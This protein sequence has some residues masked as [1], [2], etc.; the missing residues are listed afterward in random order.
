MIVDSDPDPLDARTA[1]EFVEL[2]RRLRD[3]A[4]LS[5]RQLERRAETSGDVLPASTLATALS[6]VTLPRESL[7]VAFVRACGC[8]T[9]AWVTARRQLAQRGHLR[10]AQR[11][12]LRLE[13]ER[14]FAV[15]EAT[16]SET[17]SDSKVQTENCEGQRT[18]HSPFG[19]T[20]LVGRRDVLRGLGQALDAAAD[21]AFRLVALSG[22]PGVGKTRLLSELAAIAAMRNLPTLV[23]R[24]TE[25][26]QEMPFEVLVD[27][28]DD[29]LDEQCPELSQESAQLLTTVFPSLS[30]MYSKDPEAQP[31]VDLTGLAGYRLCRAMRHL[32]EEL[33]GPTGLVL[34]LDDVHWADD[35]S[36]GLLEHIARHPPRA[37]VLVAMAYRPAQ[38]PAR[39]ATLV[40]TAAGHGLRIFVDPLTRA[41]VEQLFGQGVSAGRA[42]FLYAESG[43]NPFY[44][45]ALAKIGPSGLTAADELTPKVNSGELPPAVQA[46]LQ[47]ELN[48]LSESTRLVA[49]AAAVTADEFEPALIA[50]AAEVSEPAALAAVDELAAR[51]IIRPAAGGQFRFRHPLLRRSVYESAAAGWRL[52][53]HARVAVFLA[54]LGAPATAR[55]RHVERSGHFGD[56]DAIATLAEAARSVAPHATRAAAHWLEAALRLTP[57][58]AS[59]RVNLLLELAKL[60]A[61]SGRLIESR[62]A[63]REVLR[64]LPADAA[65]LR[66]RTARVCAMM[67]RLLDR[68]REGLAVLTAELRAI[69]DP[70]SAP[71]VLLRLRLVAENLLNTD[72]QT[73]QAI[74]DL[75]P[76]AADDWE[77]GLKLAVAAMR[78]MPAY[79]HGRI[80]DALRYIETADHLIEMAPDELLADWLDAVAFL[81]WTELFLGRCHSAVD[82]LTRALGIARATGQSYMVPILLAGQTR[83]Y[84]MLGRLPE[85]GANAEEAVAVAEMMGS[86]SLLGFARAQQCLVASWSGQD[87]GTLVRDVR[88]NH[89]STQHRGWYGNMAQ[90]MYAIAL[91]NSAEPDRGADLL[92]AVWDRVG[93]LGLDQCTLLSLCEML[94]NVEASEGRADKAAQ[95]AAYAEQVAHPTLEIN[96][97]IT[98][99][100]QAH[101]S[102]ANNPHSATALA[103]DAAVMLETAG[104]RLDAGRARL[105]AGIAAAR[106]GDQSLASTELS[107]AVD[108]FETAGAWPYHAQAMNERARS[109]SSTTA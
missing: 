103:H 32:L 98:R 71:A 100:A 36:I 51:D 75:V 25:F 44:L 66:A 86:G 17:L 20:P 57:E 69:P 108:I 11:G 83:A 80:E 78:P 96:L 67:E 63:A 6:R 37:G 33:A 39:L 99:L 48:G 94:A 104:H 68:P 109:V 88:A 46:A 58:N 107:A 77:P 35:A 62:A 9:A 52:S 18:G 27:A 56:P 38:S 49:Q 2:M 19:H 47:S 14:R 92:R 90:Y 82:R 13:D 65:Y 91:I 50:A 1:A 61:V 87:E 43:G 34:V 76:D 53:V 93:A 24:A 45:E 73:A 22:E 89:V 4:G 16:G 55:A 8:D 79:G 64:L 28:L 30:A 5:Y 12:D 70:V 7:V 42:D 54:E 23:G 60:H 101:A 105:R 21:G 81:C 95:W 59:E 26:E 97:A 15:A 106:V 74:L 31:A 85:A 29:R 10:L 40:D 72:Y 84:A 41:E 3:W 102:Q